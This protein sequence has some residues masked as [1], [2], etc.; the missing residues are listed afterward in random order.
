MATLVYAQ[1]KIADKIVSRLNSVKPGH[2][3][4][5][6]TPQGFRVIESLKVGQYDDQIEPSF[7]SLEDAAAALTPGISATS[8]V[9]NLA[10]GL[11]DGPVPAPAAPKPTVLENLAAKLVA[12]NALPTPKADEIAVLMNIVSN[13]KQY[14][15]TT[16]NSGKKWILSKFTI[17]AWANVGDG[18]IKIVV[19]KAYA[20]KK[21]LLF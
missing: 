15:T 13:G 4:V 10:A 9:D 20:K 11:Y 3:T 19:P 7:Q 8:V 2:W 1:A 17:I 12:A 14:L 5:E 18:K 16:D 6:K 21:G